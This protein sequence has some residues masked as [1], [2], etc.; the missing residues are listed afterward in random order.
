MSAALARMTDAR[1]HPIYIDAPPYSANSGGVRALHLLC[2]HLNRLGY[3]AYIIRG[4]PINATSGLRTPA[5]GPVVAMRHKIL[6][7]IPIVVYPEVVAGNP[8]RGKI[9]VRFLLNKPGLLTPGVERTYGDGDYFIHYT[10]EHGIP[11][12]KS[13]DAF[14]PLVDRNTYYPAPPEA[15]RQGFVLYSFRANLDGVVLPAWLAP[16]VSV[17]MRHPRSHQELAALYRQSRAM[18]TFERS[19]AILEAL[20]CGC[21]VICMEREHLSEGKTYQR[22]FQGAGLIWGWREE[23]VGA[24]AAE[25][26]TFREAYDALER[27]TPERLNAAFQAIASDFARRDANSPR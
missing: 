19:T 17:S 7:R 16:V 10:E 22:L 14:M 9:V 3:E 18:V 23:K 2:D 21:P 26:K 5:L 8:R 6:R 12:R 13:L 1:V 27:S 15:V 11:G 4:A 20:H 25:T 24:A